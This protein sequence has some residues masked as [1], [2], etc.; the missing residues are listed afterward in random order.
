MTESFEKFAKLFKL[1]ITPCQPIF[2]HILSAWNE[3]DRPNVLFV[4]YE[5]MKTDLDSV[6][7]NLAT[8][9]GKKLTSE[10]RAK[11]VSYV[12]VESFRRNKFVNKT[13]E[14]NPNP[15][16]GKGR[17]INDVTLIFTVFNPFPLLELF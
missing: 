5:E 8:F 1:G 10:Q 12:D 16:P 15:K 3:R 14:I 7:E 2:K 4:M 13:L 6:M 9:L 11:I 17:C